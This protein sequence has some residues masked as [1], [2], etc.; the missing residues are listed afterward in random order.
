MQG[1]VRIMKII[2]AIV[3][4]NRKEL[5]KECIEA[6]L[7]QTWQKFQIVV[8]DNA[9]TDG[10]KDTLKEYMSKDQIIYYNTGSNLG[11]A[12]GFNRAIRYALD[13]KAD[14]IWLMDDDT[15]P[16]KEALEKMLFTA[17]KLSNQFGFLSGKVLWKDG[18]LCKMNEQ[19]NYK[20]I[21]RIAPGEEII[22]C[23]QATFV[24]FF[25]RASVVKE[26]G[27]PISD[28]FIW[29]DDV[30]YSRR[31]SGKY[32][33]Y[34]VPESC[35]VHKTANNVGSNIARDEYSRISRY[36]FAYRNE[37]YI[38]RQEG[39]R[40]MIYQIGK[41]FY[42]ILKILFLA[43]G[44]RLEKMQIVIESSFNGIKFNPDIEYYG[45]ENT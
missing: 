44:N 5:L 17:G 30:E 32:V 34:Y 15:M 13:E 36:K 38:A 43:N 9:S 2:A 18:K 42:H 39:L 20:L 23:K 4:Y 35:V 3:T 31:I 40:R 26:V 33:S 14:Y 12:G 7:E 19:K 25:V 24:S 41:I 21:K 6:L 11:G 10:T 27:L 28:F 22:R 45:T 1:D 29:G 37:M 16:N 8:V